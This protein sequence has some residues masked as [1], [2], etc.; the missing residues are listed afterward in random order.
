M[1]AL[2][3]R[4]PDM[5]LSS[6]ALMP[7]VRSL[8]PLR[9]GHH[10]LALQHHEQHAHR[11]EEDQNECERPADRQHH[12]EGADDGDDGD[13]EVLRAVVREFGDFEQVGGN[14]RHELSCA[15]P[16]RRSGTRASAGA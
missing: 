4:A 10:A 1:K 3:T 2:A 9:R 6:S 5:L 12:D 7:A 13:E 8:D 15:V 14:A 16:V 11:H